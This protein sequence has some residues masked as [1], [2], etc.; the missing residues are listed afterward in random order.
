[1]KRWTYNQ[2]TKAAEDSIKAHM[3]TDNHINR[4]FASG[5][6]L[7]WSKLTMGWQVEGDDERLKALIDGDTKKGVNAG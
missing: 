6:Y 5:T 2:L 4:C 1:M 3:A 7:L